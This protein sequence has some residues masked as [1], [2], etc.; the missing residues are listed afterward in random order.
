MCVRMEAEDEAFHKG[1]YSY[2]SE[3]K[4]LFDRLWEHVSGRL[5]PSLITSLQTYMEENVSI[6][7][8]ITNLSLELVV[9]SNVVYADTYGI[10]NGKPSFLNTLIDKSNSSLKLYAPEDILAEV[11]RAIDEDLP[12]K[13]S[14]DKAKQIAKTTLSKFSI[15]EN[16]K[17]DALKK[18]ESLIG[19]RDKKDVPFLALS[20]SMRTHGII[21]YDEDFREGKVKIWRLGEAGHMLTDINK[22][23]FSFL[24]I[25]N[26]LPMLLE[27]C[28]F[29]C[30]SILNFII[31]AIT[32]L[33]ELAMAFAKG[34]LDAISRI[35]P[36]ILLAV[37]GILVLSYIF[38]T[39]VRE[40][41]NAFIGTLA[42]IAKR[43]IAGIKEIFS[44]ILEFLKEIFVMLKPIISFSLKG[45]GYLFYLSGGLIANMEKL[46]GYRSI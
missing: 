18:A 38:I 43:I 36:E 5:G 15:I 26:V 11:N 32:G 24:L 7:R 45:I 17:W 27:I 12:K 16:S 6:F 8:N 33:V 44:A 30:V 46:E 35:P 22:G 34:S 29:M 39:E 10:I 9:D 25:G 20:F 3:Q 21:T 40:G 4:Y 37:G 1:E 2:F 14:K 42:D 13:F 28:Y 41:M 19:K 23:A 31:S